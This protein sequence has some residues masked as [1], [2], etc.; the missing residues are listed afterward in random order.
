LNSPSGPQ[1]SSIG[2]LKPSA[3]ALPPLS[4]VVSGAVGDLGTALLRWLPAETAHELGMKIL[5]SGLLERIQPPS[6]YVA[7]CRTQLPGLGELPHP[8]GLAA[9]FDKNAVAPGA[10]ARLGFSFLEIGTVTPRA[11]EGNPRPRMFRLPGQRAIINRMGF[12]S[13]GAMTVA[14]R[15]ESL[16]WDLGRVPLGVNLGKN[17]DT[18]L[19]RAVHDFA[20][21]VEVF[22]NLASHFIVNISS[23]NTP[24]LRDLATPSFIRELAEAL[25]P[26][27]HKTWIKLDPDMGRAAFSEVVE[28][29]LNSGFVGI[30]LTNTHRVVHPETGG[31]SGHPLLLRSTTM[32]EWAWEVHQGRLPMIGC[33][34]VLSG[35][36]VL[37]KICRGASAVQIWSALVWRGPWVVAKLLEELMDEMKLRGFATIQE[38]HG[39]HWR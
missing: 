13:D 16:R 8:I 29:I 4:R 28:S 30:V 5:R 21:G 31:L 39:S 19:D 26:V 34:G 27:R 9:G 10:F 25:D 3:R 36:D 11:Q 6:T 33:G 18:P 20:Q 12:N 35:A 38:A 2:Q 22:K 15:L 23:P 1:G 32:L 7:G 24:G 17:R 14:R 37:E